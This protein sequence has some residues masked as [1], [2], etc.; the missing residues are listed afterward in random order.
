LA[1]LLHGL[2]L[3][4]AEVYYRTAPLGLSRLWNLYA[5]DRPDLKDPVTDAAATTGR[6]APPPPPSSGGVRAA[7]WRISH[8]FRRLMTSKR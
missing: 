8:T 2:Q 3:T 6:D 1:L 5:L 7:W 4:E